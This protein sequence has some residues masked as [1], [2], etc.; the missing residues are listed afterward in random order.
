MLIKFVNYPVRF[1]RSISLNLIRRYCSDSNENVPN[2]SKTVNNYET[3]LIAVLNN[4]NSW[5]SYK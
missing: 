2:P 3:K 5:E 4:L 1:G